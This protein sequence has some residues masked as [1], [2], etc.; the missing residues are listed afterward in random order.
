MRRRIQAQRDTFAYRLAA[1]ELDPY[2]SGKKKN[3]FGDSPDSEVNPLESRDDA[4]NKLPQGDSSAPYEQ[5]AEAEANRGGYKA[6]KEQVTPGAPSGHGGGGFGGGAPAVGGGGGTGTPIGNGGVPL[7]QNPDGT[8]TSSDPAWA[9]L[10]NRES[11]GR[12]IIQSPSTQD[13]NSGGN[14]AYGLFQITPGTWSAHGGQGSVYNST[15]QEQAAVAANILRSNPSG[16]DWGAGL[17]GRENAQALAQGLG[18]ATPAKPATGGTPA[19]PTN[20]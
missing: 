4:I 20:V 3:Y 16:S 6:P 2:S 14:E 18:S 15:P 10:I 17:S 12:N 13:V 19:T 11:G 5:A 8:W 9:H 1:D 7:V